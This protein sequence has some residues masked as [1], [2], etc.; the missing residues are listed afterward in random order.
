MHA[1]EPMGVT[2]NEV[3]VLDSSTFVREIGLTSKGG[4]ALK[5][6]LYLRGIQLVVPE[7][8]AEECEQHPD[9]TR[10]GKEKDSQWQFA[11]AGD[12]SWEK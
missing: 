10:G 9:Q 2:A 5:H 6:Y 12:G 8:V 1:G 7:V 4:S 3:L 11:V